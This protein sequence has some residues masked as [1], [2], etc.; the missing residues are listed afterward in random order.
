MTTTRHKVF[1]CHLEIFAWLA[2]GLEGKSPMSCSDHKLF[3]PITR[4][5]RGN[6]FAALFFHLLL[7]TKIHRS[8]CRNFALPPEAAL[9]FDC[10]LSR[11]E[12]EAIGGDEPESQNPFECAGVRKQFQICFL[13]PEREKEKKVKL[14]G[15][16]R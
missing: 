12:L 2:H 16:D 4:A 8:H 11:S 13:I 6:R 3:Q 1:S 7:S 15:R 9:R 10:F 5:Q 14:P